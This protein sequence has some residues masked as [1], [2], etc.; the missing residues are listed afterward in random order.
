M[1]SGQHRGSETPP[2]EQ[3]A[4]YS[5]GVWGPLAEAKCSPEPLGGPVEFTRGRWLNRCRT[6]PKA[7][8]AHYAYIVSPHPKVP[9][10]VSC[11]DAHD[12]VSHPVIT[13]HPHLRSEFGASDGGHIASCRRKQSVHI[14]QSHS[15]KRDPVDGK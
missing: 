11:R 1:L 15:R 14:V 12:L 9:Y 4:P 3:Y 7:C 10:L 8:I 6:T 5:G 13:P 2:Q